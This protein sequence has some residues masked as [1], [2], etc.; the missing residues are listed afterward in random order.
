MRF[1]WLWFSLI[2]NDIITHIFKAIYFYAF[3]CLNLHTL[4]L[5]VVSDDRLSKNTDNT[6]DSALNAINSRADALCGFAKN[7]LDTRRQNR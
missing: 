6:N 4:K 2:V 7:Q 3:P 5:I 1:I